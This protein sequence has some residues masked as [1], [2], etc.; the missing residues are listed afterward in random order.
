MR[1]KPHRTAALLAFFAFLG[2]PLA[3]G[4]SPSS[5]SET[6]SA[7][8]LGEGIYA[9]HRDVL[10]GTGSRPL[11]K[12]A[13]DV[14]RFSSTP[15]LGAPGYIIE[16]HGKTRDQGPQVLARFFRHGIDRW[17]PDGEMRFALSEDAYDDLAGTID[18]LL[19]QGTPESRGQVRWICMDGPG[20][21]TE[22]LTKGRAHWLSGFCGDNPNNAIAALLDG[23]LEQ[24]VASRLPS[25]KTRKSPRL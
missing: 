25:L 20:F 18:E 6:P 19:A 8:N 2:S 13:D 21:V 16:L 11:R 7:L 15:A 12:I 17:D 5:A 22:R 24:Q 10:N 3:A 9:A 1:R 14:I 4:A 23:L